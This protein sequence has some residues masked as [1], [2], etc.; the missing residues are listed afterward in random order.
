M[1]F[2]HAVYYSVEYMYEYVGTAAITPLH[3]ALS[4]VTST[5]LFSKVVPIQFINTSLL[6]RCTSI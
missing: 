5:H 6:R 4:S 3:A 2:G 1:Y